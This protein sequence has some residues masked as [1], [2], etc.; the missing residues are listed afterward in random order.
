MLREHKYLVVKIK[1]ALNHLTIDEYETLFRLAC[2]VDAGRRAEG[3]H[4]MKCVVVECDWPEYKPTWKAIADRVYTEEAN[5]Q[6]ST[7]SGG[8]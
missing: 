3:K 4:K 2:K 7:K 8:K 5:N 6:I 1:D